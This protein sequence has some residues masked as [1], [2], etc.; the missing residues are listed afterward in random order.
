MRAQVSCEER[1]RLGGGAGLARDEDQGPERVE[2]VEG[3]RDGGRVGRVEDPQREVAVEAA[4]RAVEDVRGQAAAAHARDDGGRVALLDDPVAESFEAGGLLREMGRRIEPAE[5]VEDGLLDAR[6]A[7]TTA[8][9][10][11]R[12]AG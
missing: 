8:S 4:E 7:R 5:A 11:A 1:G 2:V 10:R 6:I 9:R 12:T 3:G